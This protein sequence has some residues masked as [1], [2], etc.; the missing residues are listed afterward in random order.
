M[1]RVVALHFCYGWCG[2]EIEAQ[3]EGLEAADLRIT[4]I[5]LSFADE[6]NQSLRFELADV[7]MRGGTHARGRDWTTFA[8]DEEDA[9]EGEDEDGSPGAGLSAQ[10]GPG[11]SGLSRL[12]AMGL[13]PAA[14]AAGVPGGLSTAGVRMG[15]PRAPLRE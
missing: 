2:A 7:S 11:L 12:P 8:L 4:E 10:P 6:N 3:C 13:G 15:V 1:L 5:D 14:G 9:L